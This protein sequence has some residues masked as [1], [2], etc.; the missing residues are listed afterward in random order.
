MERWLRGGGSRRTRRRSCAAVAVPG[1]S[2]EAGWWVC[3]CGGGMWGRMGRVALS[4]VG[5]DLRTSEL[6]SVRFRRVTSV[7]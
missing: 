6:I 1:D 7:F 2:E 4:D 3:G 5:V